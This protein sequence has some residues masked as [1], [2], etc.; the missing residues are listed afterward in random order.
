MNLFENVKICLR[1]FQYLLRQL[2]LILFADSKHKTAALLITDLGSSIMYLLF[3]SRSESK[4]LQ[5]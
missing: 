2:F 3:I 4:F 1:T 5:R